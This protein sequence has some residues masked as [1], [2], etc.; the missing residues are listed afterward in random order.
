MA[1]RFGKDA[2]KVSLF[3]HS[4]RNCRHQW[5]PQ[6]GAEVADSTSRYSSD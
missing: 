5:T 2:A 1:A 4:N 3:K 6:R